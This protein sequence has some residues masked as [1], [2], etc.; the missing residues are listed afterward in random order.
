LLTDESSSDGCG[1]RGP[2]AFLR[3]A[4]RVR[5]LLQAADESS[6]SRT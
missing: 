3:L 1:W 2:I 4:Y 5:V 6:M